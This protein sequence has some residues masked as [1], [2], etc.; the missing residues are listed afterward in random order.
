VV[1]VRCRGLAIRDETGKPIRML[2]A[3]TDLTAV[4]RLEE[5]ARAA[6][7]AAQDANE[8][9]RAFAYSISHDLKAPANTLAMILDEMAQMPAAQLADELPM[10]LDMG[11]RTVTH[12]QGQIDAVLDFTQM[13]GDGPQTDLVD[14]NQVAKDSLSVL[15]ADIKQSQAKITILPLPKVLGARGQWQALFQNLLSNAIKFRQKDRPP[16]VEV[17]FDNGQDGMRP[18]LHFSDNGIGIPEDQLDRIFTLFERLHSRESY[19][20]SGIGLAVCQRIARGHGA[21][22]TVHST[23]G[24]G[25]RFSLALPPER[26][27]A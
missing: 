26:I 1:W 2:G 25:T 7:K 5:E 11:R 24:E 13:L 20:G 8:D 17:G 3:H 9:L 15:A 18:A 16:Q 10:L 19:E 6:T 23:V 27:A 21:E 4:K 12:M 14:L 22:L